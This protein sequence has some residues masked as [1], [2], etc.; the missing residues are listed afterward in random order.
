M[1][2]PRIDDQ[3]CRDRQATA[4]R[5]GPRATAA[6]GGGPL[7]EN[8]HETLAGA[9]H[10]LRTLLNAVLGYA[11][12]LLMGADGDLSPAAKR[13]VQALYDNSQRL[14][15]PIE[16]IEDALKTSGIRESEPVDASV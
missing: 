2:T 6:G 15:R 8:T 7:D 10:Q 13:D 14:V 11:E 16:A 3:F 9:S 4:G 12:L 1:T 5:P